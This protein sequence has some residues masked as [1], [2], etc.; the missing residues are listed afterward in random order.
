MLSQ[1]NA[2]K[3]V[4]TIFATFLLFQSSISSAKTS[5]S[6]SSDG[7][8]AIA[9]LGTLE[10]KTNSVRRSSLLNKLSKEL[11]S[12]EVYQ[13]L[14][15]VEFV[16]LLVELYEKS[17]MTESEF[18]SKL[19]KI[20]SDKYTRIFEKHTNKPITPNSIESEN[21]VYKIQIGTI[22]DGNCE[23]EKIPENINEIEVDLRGNG[24]GQMECAERILSKLLSP[25]VHQY[26]IVTNK[27]AETR[28]VHGQRYINPKTMTVLVDGDTAS[29]AEL[30]MWILKEDGYIINGGRTFGKNMIQSFYPSQNYNYTITVGEFKTKDCTTRQC[31]HL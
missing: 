21:N 9:R 27:S 17:G 19:Y 18:L 28:T 11:G 4:M 13:N 6:M 2:N 29:S 14:D 26:V 5:E 20:T 1:L 15:A 23:L 30:M 22:V 7:V 10:F 12:D 24:G 8:Y 31:R 25:K 16:E 3:M